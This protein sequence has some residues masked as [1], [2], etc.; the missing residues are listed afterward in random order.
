M[1]SKADD[2]YPQVLQAPLFGPTNVKHL[3]CID[4]NSLD[5]ITVYV[6]WMDSFQCLAS[7]NTY[8]PPEEQLLQI[9]NQLSIN[10][11]T[12]EFF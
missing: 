11:K 8:V 3:I 12:P 6:I 4:V 10:L 7:T 1:I 5:L 9:F 2:I